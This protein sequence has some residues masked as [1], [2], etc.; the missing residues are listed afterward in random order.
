MNKHKWYS[1]SVV[2]LILML[3]SISAM[4]CGPQSQISEVGGVPSSQADVPT[5]PIPKDYP[6]FEVGL[7][8]I[9][10]SGVSSG[11]VAT[12]STTVTNTGDVKGVYKAVLFVDGKEAEQ[13]DIP[14][15]P[16]SAEKV[17]FQVAKSVPGSYKL[18]IG[19]SAA[20]LTVYKWPYKI[21][22]DAGIASPDLLSVAGE[23]GHMVHF[24]PPT[25]PFKIQKIEFYV[26]TRVVDESDWADRYATVRIW[27]SD[28]NKQLWSV[29]VPWRTFWDEKKSFWKEID[30]PNIVANG[31]FYVEIVTHSEQFG[32]E[33][34][35]TTPWVPEMP[36]AIFL[37][38]DRPPN[39][40]LT[41]PLS[42]EETNSNLSKMGE[43]VEVPVKYQGINWLIR[44]EGD[45]KL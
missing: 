33:I 38:Y 39:P 21:Q 9:T 10:R 32:D 3:L 44:A 28:R 16:K 20:T 36:P 31:D 18:E 30:V 6:D 22:Y 35:A 23:L 42:P 37:G 12:V 17:T 11:E 13:K 43:V 34:I 27:D 2:G 29:N 45:G 7:L 26:Q 4:A 1:F 14:V 25:T 15:G 19:E 41:T 40:Y 8:D 24:S 5:N